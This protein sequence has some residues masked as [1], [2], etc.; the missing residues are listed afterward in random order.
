MQTKDLF[1]KVT[2]KEEGEKTRGE[3]PIGTIGGMQES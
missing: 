2:A 3:I 1:L